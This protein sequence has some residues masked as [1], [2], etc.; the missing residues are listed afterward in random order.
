MGNQP[1]LLEAGA[2]PVGRH[3]SRADADEHVLEHEVLARLVVQAVEQA[4]LR[5]QDVHSLV[6][7]QCRPYTL[8]KYFCTFMAHYLRLPSSAT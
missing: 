5:K 4:G 1:V 7:A 8:Q 3:Q 2:I 6:L